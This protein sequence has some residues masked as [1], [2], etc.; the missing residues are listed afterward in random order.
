MKPKPL[1]QEPNKFTNQ[2][3]SNNSA[4]RSKQTT[5]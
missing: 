5:A 4:H 2:I 3:F 1:S